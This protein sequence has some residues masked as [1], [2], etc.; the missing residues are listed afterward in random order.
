FFLSGEGEGRRGQHQVHAVVRQVVQEAEGVADEHGSA[1]GAVRRPTLPPQFR[2]PVRRRRV[3]VALE[4][5]RPRLPWRLKAFL[6]NR[7]VMRSGDGCGYLP[8]GADRVGGRSAAAV[9]Q[10]VFCRLS[11]RAFS[12]MALACSRSAGRKSYSGTSVKKKLGGSRSTLTRH[13]GRPPA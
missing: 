8:P 6:D 13:S 12:T 10:P 2:R 7:R 3:A 1:L 11:A 5:V 4:H 9:S